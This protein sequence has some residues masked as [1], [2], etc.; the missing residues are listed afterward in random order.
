MQKRFLNLHEYQSKELMA[1]HQINTQ[2]FQVVTLV[3]QVPDALQR[4]SI[5]SEF[6]ALN[7]MQ[8]QVNMSSRHKS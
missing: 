3:E 4:L 2:R 8:M 7:T 6:C 5:I 1:N